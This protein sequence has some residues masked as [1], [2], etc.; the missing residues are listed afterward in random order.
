MAKDHSDTVLCLA[1][2]P[3]V[4][5]IMASGGKDR[6]VRVWRL[7]QD[8]LECLVVGSGHTEALGGLSWGAELSQLVTVSKDTTLKVWSLNIADKTLTS[9]RTEIAHE[10]DFN[11]V[12]VSLSGADAMPPSSS[13]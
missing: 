7:E 4:T 1:T 3:W 5:S 6:E 10:K 12:A 2:C 9:I 8:R 13:G 11:C